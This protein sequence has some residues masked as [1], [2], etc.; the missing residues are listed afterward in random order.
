M[1]DSV[2]LV[3]MLHIHVVAVV[4][5]F[6]DSISY[7]FRFFCVFFSFFD[8][9]VVLCK[10]ILTPGYLILSASLHSFDQYEEKATQEKEEG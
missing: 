4:S 3:K 8:S 5:S 7:F 1:S 6:V 10:M 2:L 9:L